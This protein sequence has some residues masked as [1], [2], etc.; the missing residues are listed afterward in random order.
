MPRMYPTVPSQFAYLTSYL[1]RAGMLD[2][3]TSHPQ[4]QRK[5]PPP[6]LPVG[7]VQQP[8][9]G[10]SADVH[11]RYITLLCSYKPA[12]VLA[13]LMGSA[14]YP[15]E[16]T[17]SVVQTAGILEAVAYLKEHTGDSRGAL[18]VRGGAGD[19]SCVTSETFA[20]FLPRSQ[21]LCKGLDERA[22]E[23]KRALDE[24]A[25]TALAS[26]PA[27]VFSSHQAA[28]ALRAEPPAA[29]ALEAFSRALGAVTDLCSRTSAK[30]GG[31]AKSQQLWFSVLDWIVAQ[32]E[33]KRHS[34][35][36]ATSALAAH[37]P[38][39]AA[40]AEDAAAVAS[41]SA[42][43][44]HMT[45]SETLQSVMET[46]RRSVPLNV[47]LKKVL[48]D[49]SQSPFGEF[50]GV[51]LAMLGSHAHDSRIL[52][53]AGAMMKADV[54]SSV[55]RLHTGFASAIN[56]CNGGG[57][58]GSSS[59]L[60]G[61]D[62]GAGAASSGVACASCGG[63]LLA[64]GSQ[65]AGGGGGVL[66]GASRM[67]S[68]AVFSANGAAAP[69]DGGGLH[70]VF[71]CGH[72]FHQGC[73]PHVG[74]ASHAAALRATCPLCTKASDTT[75]SATGDGGATASPSRSRLR[76][77]TLPA[78]SPGASSLDLQR[79]RP[80]QAPPEGDSD[81]DD[82][83]A[84]REG[85]LALGRSGVAS[86][87][88]VLGRNTTATS[89]A[90]QAAAASSGADE[91]DGD[92]HVTRLRQ[93][94]AAR[95]GHRPLAELFSELRRPPGALQVS[96]SREDVGRCRVRALMGTVTCPRAPCRCCCRS[97]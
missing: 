66:R 56:A 37:K 27:S 1:R 23:L 46:M 4:D 59:V 89:A 72:S 32:Q 17:L 12:A 78:G 34:D 80:M 68:M 76:G 49:H 73:L 55:R 82:A 42:A 67:V 95:A 6:R 71:G 2:E 63:L 69:A 44:L 22:A 36:D 5:A 48:S 45:M 93:A 60:T 58:N 52:A 86:G 16:A 88:R 96:L 81:D 62:A 18:E 30:Y 19:S 39:V 21:V 92:P 87:L 26:H 90:A 79:L 9:A 10:L 24:A 8:V 57:G 15:L 77:S 61:S 35:A 38:A 97:L 47:V 43:A 65:S 50:R 28:S 94:R 33:E 25:V 29:S 51:I 3:S 74:G 40:R 53:T 14:T 13:Y 31:D 83:I 70:C 91:D 75:A 41:A 54:Y 11:L 64:S 7:S 85:A 84:A 20:N